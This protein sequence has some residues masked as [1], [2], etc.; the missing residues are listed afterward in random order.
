MYVLN[1]PKYSIDT[2]LTNN[3][4]TIFGI[5]VM[6]ATVIGLVAQFLIHPYLNQIVALYENKDLKNLKKLLTKLILLIIGFG[7]ISIIL[8]YLFGTQILGI[9]Y[10]LDL[11][12]YKIGLS[13]I[14]LSAIFYAIGT[15][16]SQF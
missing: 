14:I 4:Q 16:Y 2:Y 11:S 5:I 15:I 13:I 9:I 7:V 10:G 12:S 1:A 3:Y 6:P 8:A